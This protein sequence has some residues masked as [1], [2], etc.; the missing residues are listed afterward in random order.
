[1]KEG[2][3]EKDEDTPNKENEKQTTVNP[4]SLKRGSAVSW[5]NA[6]IVRRR[7]KWNCHLTV[8]DLESGDL[9][10]IYTCLISSAVLKYGT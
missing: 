3:R 8:T 6:S 10:F 4:A 2:I 7:S 9:Q 5:E 1:M